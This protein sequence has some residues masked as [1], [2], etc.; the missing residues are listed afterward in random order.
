MA[1]LWMLLMP[2]WGQIA[3]VCS[4]CL[5]TVILFYASKTIWRWYIFSTAND[6]T[7]TLTRDFPLPP[8]DFGIPFLGETLSW[9]RQVNGSAFNLIRRK[10]YGNIF[11]THFL[12]RAMV[13]ITGAENVRQI[14][15]GEHDKVTTIWPTTIRKILGEHSIANSVGEEHRH[16]RKFAMKGFTH[17]ALNS[18]ISNAKKIISEKVKQW[19]DTAGPRKIYDDILQMTFEVSAKAMVGLTFPSNDDRNKA[20]STFHEMVKNLFSLPYDLPFSGFRKG[21][22]C[23][24]ILHAMLHEH[25]TKKIKRLQ[26]NGNDGDDGIQEDNDVMQYILEADMEE[27]R[28]KQ[29]HCWD[30]DSERSGDENEKCGFTIEEL[31]QNAV[32]LMFAGFQTTGSSISSLMIQ[33]AKH[34]DVRKKVEDE[35]E[36]HGFLGAEDS[37]INLERIQKLTY[38]EQVI[39]ETLRVMPPILGGYRRALKTFE[40]GGYRIPKDWTIIY[41]IRD[42]HEYEF[43]DDTEFNPERFSRQNWTENRHNRFRWLPFGGGARTCVGKEFA[44]LMIKLATIELFRN[45]QS[46]EFDGGKQPPMFPIPTLHPTNGLPLIFT[47]RQNTV[48]NGNVQFNN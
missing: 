47:P 41:N 31:K 40:I 15:Q 20:F 6:L 32:E 44:K 17:S 22:Q 23:K 8:G 21:Y 42:T 34:S 19:T 5:S 39:K 29:L 35:L 1:G 28:K 48:S 16:L 10:K 46:W 30:S 9:A 37:E 12:G 38:L 26:C 3:S 18:Y 2:L 45:F 43:E 4:Y 25:L 24:E 33:L 14:L 27:N 7:S 36:E 11:S 13:K